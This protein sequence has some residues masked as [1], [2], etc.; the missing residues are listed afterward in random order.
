MGIFLVWDNCPKLEY[1]LLEFIAEWRGVGTII[2]YIILE[3]NYNKIIKIRRLKVFMQ[4]A[5][6]FCLKIGRA[7]V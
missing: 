6:R 1:T 5:K 2:L 4:C 3:E 7:H